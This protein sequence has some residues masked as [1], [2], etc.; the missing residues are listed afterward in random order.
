MISYYDDLGA[1]Y[2]DLLVKFNNF[3]FILFEKVVFLLWPGIE[4]FFLISFLI[5]ALFLLFQR[6]S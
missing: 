6:T 1:R 4:V 5:V 2:A 3:F